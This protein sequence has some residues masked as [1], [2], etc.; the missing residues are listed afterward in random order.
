MIRLTLVI[1]DK[2]VEF[3]ETSISA[4][5]SIGKASELIKMV[6]KKVYYLV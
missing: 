3:M 4:E 5:L 2:L 6:Y 1:I